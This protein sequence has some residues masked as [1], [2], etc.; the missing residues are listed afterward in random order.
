MSD[1]TREFHDLAMSLADQMLAAERGGLLALVHDYAS[2]AFDAELAAL[3]HAAG[4]DTSFATRKILFDSLIGLGRV[5]FLSA[6]PAAVS[7]AP[8]FP[9]SE[10]CEGC[11][12]RFPIGQMHI[13][14]CAGWWCGLCA[15]REVFL[16]SGGEED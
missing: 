11:S 2:A 1:S 9:D 5:A 8:A 13:D 3:R 15:D 16:N 10:R 4:N 12:E 14:Q 7:L 6:L